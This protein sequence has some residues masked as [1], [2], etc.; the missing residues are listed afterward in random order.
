MPARVVS[1]IRP[2]AAPAARSEIQKVAD[3]IKPLS[4]AAVEL[5]RAPTGQLKARRA[6]LVARVS[7]LREFL[8]KNVPGNHHLVPDDD[9]FLEVAGAQAGVPAEP[10]A[11]KVAK[12]AGAAGG[13]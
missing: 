9:G 6:D 11:A 12:V 1:C 7:S 13:K 8:A 5:I 4:K 3:Q 2:R 10:G